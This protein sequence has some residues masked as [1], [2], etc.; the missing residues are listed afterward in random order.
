MPKLVKGR[1]I[2]FQSPPY[3]LKKYGVD[4][5]LLNQQSLSK[6]VKLIWT[7]ISVLL[8]III[9]HSNTNH[10]L[11][12]ISLFSP[13]FSCLVSATPLPWIISLSTTTQLLSVASLQVDVLLLSSTQLFLKRYRH[14][15][16]HHLHH[17]L[18]PDLWH[19][20]LLWLS[21]SLSSCLQWQGHSCWGSLSW[22]WGSYWSSREYFRRQNI[23]LPRTARH[24]STME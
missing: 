5:A 15:N 14:Q 16:L 9:V 18:L 17:P 23:Y 8:Y 2:C 1:P 21:L 7:V 4:S 20:K 19:G 12:C 13:L 22:I 10:S 11:Q 6:K 3:S 24:N